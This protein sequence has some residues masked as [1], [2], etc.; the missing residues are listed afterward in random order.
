M[1]E[2]GGQRDA[3]TFH[4]SQQ[5]GGSWNAIERRPATWYFSK[6]Q[7][8]A[9][10]TPQWWSEYWRAFKTRV[11][12]IKVQNWIYNFQLCF[13]KIFL[14]VLT[15]KGWE[16]FLTDAKDDLCKNTQILVTMGISGGV[17]CRGGKMKETCFSPYATS[18]GQPCRASYIRPRTCNYSLWNW[19]AVQ[20]V[21][22]ASRNFQSY[23]HHASRH[24]H[25]FTGHL[26]VHT[27]TPTYKHT[28]TLAQTEI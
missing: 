10:V 28:D 23:T 24:V 6:T 3:L 13:K 18:A 25:V 15:I 22:K 27:R 19:R 14:N 9:D 8:S 2:S 12:A 20:G 17:L 4:E 5:T 26:C 1:G 11:T 16:K 21:A 7:A